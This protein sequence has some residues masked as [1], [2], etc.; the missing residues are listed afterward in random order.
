MPHVVFQRVD[1]DPAAFTLDVAARPEDEM[2]DDDARRVLVPVPVR[3]R[4][5]R[6][7]YGAVKKL[8][9]EVR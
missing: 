4:S 1:A 2:P 7:V 6:C 8:V 9:R 3:T 5:V